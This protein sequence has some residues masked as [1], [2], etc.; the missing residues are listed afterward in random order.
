MP[1]LL[2]Q[3]RHQAGNLAS[4]LRHACKLIQCRRGF[5]QAAALDQRLH[6][7]ALPKIAIGVLGKSPDAVLPKRNGA[8]MILLARRAA[9]QARGPN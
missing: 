9:R 5:R 3:L 2:C 1:R 4:A 6:N 7:F 8:D